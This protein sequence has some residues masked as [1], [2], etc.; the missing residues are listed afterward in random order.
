MLSMPLMQ[1]QDESLQIQEVVNKH[2]EIS[3]LHEIKRNALM[4]TSTV[5]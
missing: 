4:K 3:L 5:C 1:Y 2:K